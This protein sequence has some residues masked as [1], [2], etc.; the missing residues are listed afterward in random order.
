MSEDKTRLPVLGTDEG[1]GW[2]SCTAVRG[3]LTDSEVALLAE[4][5]EVKR[6]LRTASRAEH[7]ALA[8]QLDA[9]K[10][11]REEARRERMTLLGHQP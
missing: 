11:Q 9:L 5:R 4:M 8:S 1:A 10:A 7:P 6:R 3:G 2:S